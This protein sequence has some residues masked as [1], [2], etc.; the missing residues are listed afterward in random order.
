MKE[1]A[2]GLLALV[3]LISLGARWTYDRRF[4]S[5][6]GLLYA[7]LL[8][9]S[10]AAPLSTVA[11][12][13]MTLPDVPTAGDTA[14]FETALSEAY[15]RGVRRALCE[16]FSLEEGEVTVLLVDFCVEDMAATEVSV[17]LSGRA[18]LADRHRMEAY[19][20]EGG[21]R[22]REIRIQRP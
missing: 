11:E 16:T 5:A 2:R 17:M 15:G 18:A 22:V 13:D 9:W 20:E 14:A 10:V 4:A 21:V 7:V 19:L 12:E 1:Y 3:L 6:T 8:L